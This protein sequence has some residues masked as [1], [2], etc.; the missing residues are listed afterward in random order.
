[1]DQSQGAAEARVTSAH[2]HPLCGELEDY[3]QGVGS[4]WA[5]RCRGGSRA[6]NPGPHPRSSARAEIAVERQDR[7][8]GA[9]ELHGRAS[10][11]ELFEV[12]AALG[13]LP[14]LL[15]DVAG[16]HRVA[17]SEPGRDRQRRRRRDRRAAHRRLAGSASDRSRHPGG[18]A[19]T[20]LV[21]LSAE[22]SRP[23]VQRRLRK[24]RRYG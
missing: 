7:D 1:M 18:S 16:E 8:H 14:E 4:S 11:R 17:C 3:R 9:H 10:A 6:A 24:Q 21:V 5:R 2:Q 20:P 13:E 15:G 19:R 22:W 12:A 23:I